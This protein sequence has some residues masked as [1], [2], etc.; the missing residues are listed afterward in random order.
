MKVAIIIYI[1]TAKYQSTLLPNLSLCAH[2]CH[3][4]ST[5]IYEPT[6]SINNTSCPLH[7]LSITESG[8]LVIDFL[9]LVSSDR[10]SRGAFEIVISKQDY[11]WFC[12]PNSGWIFTGK[13]EK[14]EKK[15]HTPT[16][17]QIFSYIPSLDLFSLH[18]FCKTPKSSISAGAIIFQ[19]LFFKF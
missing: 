13:D 10:R 16:H 11:K 18:T 4:I 12:T 7:S 1:P 14:R 5:K 17:L 3:M 19:L 9:W 6:P 15:P 8:T 2:K